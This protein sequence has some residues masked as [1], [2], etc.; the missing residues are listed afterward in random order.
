[1]FILYRIIFVRLAAAWISLIFL[2]NIYFM[3]F[4]RGN[5]K[6]FLLHFWKRILCCCVVVCK[7]PFIVVDLLMWYYS[8]KRKTT[9]TGAN[10]CRIFFFSCVKE[11]GRSINVWSICYVVV[12]V[13]YVFVSFFTLI[14]NYG[15]TLKIGVCK[16]GYMQICIKLFYTT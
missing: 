3:S 6:L 7:T 8:M 15:L 2:Y 16:Y 4:K 12:N 14:T 11:V 10:L 5:L 1:M 9:I 13:F